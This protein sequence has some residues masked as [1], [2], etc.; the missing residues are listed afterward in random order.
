MLLITLVCGCKD[1]TKKCEH[2][3]ILK[4]ETPPTCAIKGNK[5]FE[6]N[7]CNDSYI[8]EIPNDT[9]EHNWNTGFLTK[10][11]SC[12]EAGVR[13]YTCLTCGT[14]KEEEFYSEHI[15]LTDFGQNAT[16]QKEG[17]TEGSHCYTC[18]KIIT[19]QKTIT[20]IDH[21]INVNGECSM[22]Y[23]DFYNIKYDYFSNTIYENENKIK[24]S[25]VE[26]KVA[27][28][29]ITKTAKI[30]IKAEFCGDYSNK[31][32]S[33]YA[34]ITCRL[35]GTQSFS[36]MDSVW[37]YGSIIGRENEFTIYNVPVGD[38]VVE[39]SCY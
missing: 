8:E 1:N 7:I 28:S 30:N 23:K 34:Y 12:T 17:K 33:F 31:E 6:C 37:I 21:I 20:K 14:N 27:Y 13:T 26:Y 22:C 18:G 39:F 15:P 11:A 24:I 4:S 29:E 3:Y 5:L 9:I 36:D 2:N 32:N 16:C 10:I 35:K 19:E 25:D 38:Y